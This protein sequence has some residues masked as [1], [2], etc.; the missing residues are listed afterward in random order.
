MK[1]FHGGETFPAEED[2]ILLGCRGMI[3]GRRENYY[4]DSDVV[5]HQ[6]YAN[7][8]SIS[9]PKTGPVASV[10]GAWPGPGRAAGFSRI[11][12]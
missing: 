11:S 4:T 7:H 9:N 10:P 8:G 1:L 6:Y 12:G 2:G 3:L 5:L